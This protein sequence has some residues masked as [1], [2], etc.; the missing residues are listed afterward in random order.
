[1]LMQL[2][3]H[4]YRKTRTDDPREDPRIEDTK[5]DTITEDPK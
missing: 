1:M 5:E 2:M 4:A 3:A